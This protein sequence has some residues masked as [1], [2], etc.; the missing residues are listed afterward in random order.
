MN[1]AIS[2]IGCFAVL[3][4]VSSS[5]LRE[6]TQLSLTGNLQNDLFSS[7]AVGADSLN[8]P[9]LE[10]DRKAPLNAAIYSAI[11]PGSGQLYTESY[12]EG[13]GFVAAEVGLWVVYSAYNSKGDKR[14]AEFQDFADLHW[15]VVSYVQWMKSY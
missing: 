15:S 3:Y 8:S 5:Q 2:I 6:T 14:T 1:Q 11:L 4:Q 12:L 10:G 9:S 13:V 7:L